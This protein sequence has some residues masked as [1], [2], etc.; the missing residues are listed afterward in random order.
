MID[1]A[2]T[3]HTAERLM[4]GVYSGF[5]G[6]FGTIAYNTPDYDKMAHIEANV[7]QFS[8][9]KNYQ[10]L[11]ELTR[12]VRDGENIRTYRD[13]R[14]KAIN[15]LDEYDQRHLRTE[16]N[17]AVAGAQMAS[18]WVDYEKAAVL[19]TEQGIDEPLLQYRTQEDARV[20]DSHAAL[21]R[22]TRPVSDDFWKTY[23]PPNGWNCRC[24]TVRTTTGHASTDTDTN[25]AMADAVPQ[26]GFT[27]NLAKEGFVFPD[28]SA[29]YTD[30]PPEVLRQALNMRP[31]ERRFEKIHTSTTK[32]KAGQPG[33]VW[34]HID[35]ATTTA[36]YPLVET[37][38]RELADKGYRVE[39]LP[40][41]T[42]ASLHGKLFPGAKPGKH[43]DLRV[44]GEYVEIK[45]P[46]YP[47]GQNS[48][49]NI[50]HKAAS[51]ADHV[52][53]QTQG[54]SKAEMKKLAKDRFRNSKNLQKIEFRQ[55]GKYKRFTKK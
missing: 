13:F 21:N 18:K 53:I 52:I 54:L 50:I 47:Y 44:N 15:I 31:Y 4:Q 41:N 6:T 49:D 25:R 32:N 28:N 45:E 10:M 39:L 48:I 40:N 1:E 55:S 3:R 2:T 35:V 11:R 22:I 42:P 34:R 51:Q 24:T 30:C 20:R 7:Y 36:D 19:A 23:Y 8:G 16:Y 43:P 9:A 46:R 17:A 33:T 27:R 29:Y 14:Q 37:I 26:K 38:G 12:A 5:G